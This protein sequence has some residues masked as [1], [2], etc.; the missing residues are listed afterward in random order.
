MPGGFADPE[1]RARAAEARA[2]KKAEKDARKAQR[3]AKPSRKIG[4]SKSQVK[5]GIGLI[6]VGVDAALAYGA[7]QLWVTPEDRLN[8]QEVELL[9]EAFSTEAMKSQRALRFLTSLTAFSGRLGIAG[10]LMIVALPRLMR[11]G[12]IP[13]A[14]VP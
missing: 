9:T 7:P 3:E 1:V 5:D 10:A 13:E 11:R 12:M 14:W 8:E 2:R 4:I 6:I